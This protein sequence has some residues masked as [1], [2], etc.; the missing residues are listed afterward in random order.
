M[1]LYRTF[2]IQ[3]FVDVAI[4]GAG[5]VPIKFKYP[6]VAQT[7]QMAKGQSIAERA[8]YICKFCV[9]DMKDLEDET[10]KEIKIVL[11]DQKEAGKELPEDIVKALLNN[12]FAYDIALFYNE[13]IHIGDTDKKKLPSSPGSSEPVKP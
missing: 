10:G 12:G 3:D 9:E 1:K 13:H 11:V 6:T 7:L 4:E 5:V 8:M 2:P